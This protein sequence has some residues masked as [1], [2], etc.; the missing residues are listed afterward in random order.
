MELTKHS[1]DEHEQ[2]KEFECTMCSKKQTTASGH[3]KHMIL[4]EE[5]KLKFECEVCKKKIAFNRYLKRHMNVHTDN[6]P[7]TCPT[8]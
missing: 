4:H 5:E 6:K 3:R 8:R 1:K 7:Y 2:Q